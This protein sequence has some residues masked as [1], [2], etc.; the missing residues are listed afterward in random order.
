VSIVIFTSNGTRWSGPLP[1]PLELSIP[2]DQN[3][4]EDG[5]CA[6]WDTNTNSWSTE[7]VSTLS[8]DNRVA[9]CQTT[10]LSLFAFVLR[11]IAQI[12]ICSAASAIFSVDGLRNLRRSHWAGSVPAALHWLAL[13]LAMLLLLLAW[14]SDR[15]HE[16]YLAEL[17]VAEASLKRK[18]SASISTK[19]LILH[20]FNLRLPGF[21]RLSKQVYSAIVRQGTGETLPALEKMYSSVGMVAAHSKAHQCI[22]RFSSSSVYRKVQILYAASNVWVRITEPSRARSSVVRCLLLFAQA[23][24][25]MGGGR[26]FLQCDGACAGSRM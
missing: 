16:R 1:E 26:C 18:K 21:K 14:R 25:Q 8:I 15:A 11:T 12:F 2:L 3:T 5:E 19:D 10:H 4:T 24:Q 17:E 13:L 9:A 7:G 22:T 20:G 23:L 6:F